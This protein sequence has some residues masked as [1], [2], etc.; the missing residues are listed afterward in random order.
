[1]TYAVVA[2]DAG[3]AEILSSY[4]RQES[5][6]PLFA[7]EGPARRVFQR[8]LGNVEVVSMEE[9]VR[10]CTSVMCGTSWQSELE[11]N[12]IRMAHQLSKGSIAFVD[13]WVNYRARFVRSGETNLPDEI[14]V[15]DSIAEVIARKE[16][17]GVPI[18]LVENPY[19]NEVRAE[20]AAIGIRRPAHSA[21]VSV[22]YVCEPVREH[23]LRRFGH[24]RHFGYV[25]EEALR[26][27][28]MNLAV[29]GRPIERIHIRPHPSEPTDKYSWVRREFGLPIDVRTDRTLA[30]EIADCDVVVGCESMAM[31]VGLV[32]GKR[33]I[34]CIPPGGKP[35]GLPQPQIE[36]CQLLLAAQV[37]DAADSA[38]TDSHC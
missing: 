36:H 18:R 16:F 4:I 27:F 29:L 25:E 15:G 32:A 35:C 13:H 26:F 23:A 9:A 3:G 21:C 7:V 14:W 19:L 5:I 30:E 20:L 34:S 2:H 37:R 11:F 24:E 38:K 6:R 1:M 12:A 17:P 33:V 8:K 22:L 10:R 31:V 28:L